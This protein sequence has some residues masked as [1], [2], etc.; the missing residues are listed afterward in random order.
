[1]YTHN[2]N[3]SYR[4]KVISSVIPT[5]QLSPEYKLKS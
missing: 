5:Q 3:L 4:K 2:G 1:M